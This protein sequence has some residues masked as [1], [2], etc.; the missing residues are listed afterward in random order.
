MF[1]ALRPVV[2]RPVATTLAAC[3]I[4]IGG[5]A[6]PPARQPDIPRPSP[7]LVDVGQFVM[8]QGCE[9]KTGTMYRT[10]FT[11]EPD[12]RVT[13]AQSDSG[14]GCVQRA[15][16]EWV[17]TFIYRPI[18]IAAPVAFDWIEVKASRGG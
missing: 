18:G 3:A 10:T 4:V 12:G 11:V 5:C 2:S 6:S 15:L 1:A 13:G 7:E 16:R 9:P 14:D 8:P 17:V